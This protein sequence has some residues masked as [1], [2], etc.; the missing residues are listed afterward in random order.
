V[1]DGVVLARAGQ[2]FID[3][4]DLERVEVLKGP[5]GTLYGKNASSGVVQFV[6]R[7]PS[8][9]FEASVDGFW[10]EDAEYRVKGAVSGPVNDMVG[11]RLNAFYG[12]FDGF[13]NNLAL[14]ED[15]YGYERF[16]V[17]GMVEFTPTDTFT[18]RLTADYADA[19]DDCCSEV[20]RADNGGI[21]AFAAQQGGVV[22]PDGEG[23]LTT[24]ASNAAQVTENEHI[25]VALNADWDIGAFTLTSITAYRE[26]EN[27]ERQD[28]DDG[29]FGAT[30]R[31]GDDPANIT[32]AS[33]DGV[34]VGQGTARDFGPQTWTQW[35][36]ELRLA[37]QDN[38]VF[39]WQVG[40]FYYTSEVDRQ[41]SR[42]DAL[43]I[44]D[45]T[46]AIGGVD[47]S[48]LAATDLCPT[49]NIQLPS[50]TAFMTVDNESYAAYGHGTWFATDRLS[51]TGGIRFT[52]DE[53]SFTH[54]RER[55]GDEYIDILG[56]ND[57]NPNN[58][59]GVFA[60]QVDQGLE[61]DS[62]DNN[63]VSGSFSVNYDVSDRLF[64]Y[65]KYSRGYK[66][67]AYNVF[68][69]ARNGENLLGRPLTADDDPNF[70]GSFTPIDAETSN[71]YEIG[72]KWTFDNAYVS[73]AAF[74]QDY[75]D[76]QANNFI[77]T[78]G[79]VT[80]NLTN[81]GDVRT[82]GLEIEFLADPTDNLSLYGGVTFA[83]AEIQDHCA[84]LSAVDLEAAIANGTPCSTNK[85]VDLPFAPKMKGSFNAEYSVPLSPTVDLEIV[86]GVS[87]QSESFGV[88][89]EPDAQRI[90]GFYIYNAQVGL[91]FLDDQY[92]VAVFGRNLFNQSYI[93][94]TNEGGEVARLPR[95]Q[96]RY[97]GVRAAARF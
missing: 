10:A 52:R 12:N 79:A 29:P 45:P 96:E 24:T 59:G 51:F 23:A 36:Q 81:A 13:V 93:A 61:S 53:I 27:V 54:E 63:N 43:C 19:D 78:A 47:L 11:V 46:G 39:E 77:I 40:L 85:G 76:F 14:N 60:L 35:S 16:G 42:F 90:D 44:D 15:V 71:A 69:N 8:E 62:Q 18:A 74:R 55:V 28:I 67:P 32:L 48:G 86:N 83:D 38:D 26:W 25:G 84:S 33:V 7:G 97:F 92:T 68:F 1:V 56:N 6:S 2:A 91:S 82:E 34:L 72:F 37:S 3:L 75:S 30:E 5:Q 66:G 50:A 4:Y 22:F 73:V 70:N 41:F 89:G 31:D 94:A 58:D 95:D 65:I 49:S 9:E 21:R 64:T 88:L 17:R 87:F 57:G 80:T 20:V